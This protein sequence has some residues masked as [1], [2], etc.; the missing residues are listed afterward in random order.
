MYFIFDT[1]T[2]GLP[3]RGGPIRGYHHP[4]CLTKYDS[5]R[6]VSIAWIVLDVEFKELDRGSVLIKPDSF[7]V[8]KESTRIHGITHE[9][10]VRNGVGIR[11]VFDRL[12]DIIAKCKCIVAHN[13]WFDVNVFM[14]ECYRYENNELIALIDRSS[15]FCTMAKGKELLG[16]SRIPSL[17]NLYK[18]L[19]GD[20]LTN[21]HD[22]WFDTWHCCECFMALKHIPKNSP[23]PPKKRQRPEISY[24]SEQLDVIRESPS[25]SMLV[26][27][28]PGSGKTQSIVGRI[29]HLIETQDV[30]E[31]TIILTTFTRDG[32]RQ[33][34]QRLEA[35]LGRESSITIGTIDALSLKM[36]RD[37]NHDTDDMDLADYTPCCAAFLKTK[38]G[39][40]FS[41]QFRHLFV[42][43]FQDIN[44]DQFNI[45]K[46]RYDNDIVI[47]AVGDDAQKI[48]SF[49][50][51]DVGYTLRFSTYF[52]KSKCF[53][54][55]MNFR[56][57]PQI[58]AVANSVIE[59]GMVSSKSNGNADR[60]SLTFF[61]NL[62][63]ECN[64]IRY[65]VSDYTRNKRKKLHDI[66]I[67]CPQNHFLYCVEEHFAEHGIPTHYMNG[68]KE[69]TN[70]LCLSTIH[71]AKGLE[72]DVVFLI[73]AADNVYC[74]KES[75][76][77]EGRNLFYVGI[78]RPKEQ[79]HISYSPVNGCNKPTRFITADTH[80]LLM[81]KDIP[82]I[83]LSSQRQQKESN[84]STTIRSASEDKMAHFNS[85][86]T[87]DIYDHL[88]VPEFVHDMGIEDEYKVFVRLVL[89]R[90]LG[91]TVLNNSEHKYTFIP[92]SVALSTI[93]VDYE[94]YMVYK[95][96]KSNIEEN[97]SDVHHLL[98]NLSKN[99]AHILKMIASPISVES[100][101]VGLLLGLLKRINKSAKM[102]GIPI[103][104]VRI[105]G[106]HMPILPKPQREDILEAY[107][108]YSD[109]QNNTIDILQELW[110]VSKCY[111]VM[112]ENRKKMLHI[113]MDEA[114]LHS[115]QKSM[116][117][118][119]KHLDAMLCQKPLDIS[120]YK[121]F[122]K[123][124]N[125]HFIDAL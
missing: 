117:C 79:L 29:V 99:K 112:I 68:D 51:S 110:Q 42:D 73:V 21:A 81:R 55:T 75:Q 61:K 25:T 20:A 101:E 86:P 26:L 125:Q 116:S 8:S 57:T 69:Y 27:A 39:R 98:D 105:V 89:M 30:P 44:R 50:G 24:T 62:H 45:I 124:E 120:N 7:Y 64:H 22:A 77:Q 119:E 37:T 48:Y 52:P 40:E 122:V 23:T 118:L 63:D 108:M 113:A 10:A 93:Y 33:M 4:R 11:T 28:C 121:M 100:S 115:V 107:Y 103:E 60:A 54:L 84:V 106:K 15:K 95:K 85:W 1:E 70:K 123:I 32:A 72:W 109:A 6:V 87:T 74:M 49:R 36:L 65:M 67:L 53:K 91:E 5:S 35:A 38:K 92:A 104:C 71:K 111:H 12:I 14:S 47:A 76:E 96:Y 90:M 16:L 17:A 97:I 34:R 102:F 46:A 114:R 43:E 59:K 3:A 56:S 58:V 31:Q 13:V 82:I 66:A 94:D 78:T 80:D 88:P 19:F 9:H 18:E 41:S 2:S 83:Q